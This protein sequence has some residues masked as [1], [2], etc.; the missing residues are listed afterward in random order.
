MFSTGPM[1]L[2]HEASFYP[3]RSSINVISQELYGKY[4]YNS[5]RSL[6]RHLKGI[7]TKKFTDEIHSIVHLASSW[8]G[9]DAAF[10]KWIYHRR[11]SLLFLLIFTFVLTIALICFIQNN[12][13]IANILAKIP[14]IIQSTLRRQS[15][16]YDKIHSNII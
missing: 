14:A 15:F 1:F 5:S 7:K 11:M 13:F 2:T 6:F 9:N 3:K 4:V 12:Q 8:H 10:V 16:K